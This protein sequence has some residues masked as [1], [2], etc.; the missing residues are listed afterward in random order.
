MLL[1][2]I[3]RYRA[4]LPETIASDCVERTIGSPNNP[5]QCSAL[6]YEASAHTRPSPTPQE[7]RPPL[8][9]R[10]QRTS[11]RREG[12]R[13]ASSGVEDDADD[14]E[15]ANPTQLHRVSLLQLVGEIWRT[16]RARLFERAHSA[17]SQLSTERQPLQL[18]SCTAHREAAL[19]VE[20]GKAFRPR[21]ELR[22][23]VPGAA[24]DLFNNASPRISDKGAPRRPMD[25]PREPPVEVHHAKRAHSAGC[26]A[27]C[28]QRGNL[29]NGVLPLGGLCSI[30]P[31]LSHPGFC[32]PQ[33]PGSSEWV[34]GS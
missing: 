6:L 17:G 11:R 34:G 4:H 8:H 26:Q 33:P 12:R 13:V 14:Q 23:L 29:F 30:I 16:V 2:A 25:S 31:S 18:S 3:A 22:E 7:L 9:E 15:H 24:L 32:L 19:T 27:V 10:L 21:D 5:P 28:P 1:P 20:T